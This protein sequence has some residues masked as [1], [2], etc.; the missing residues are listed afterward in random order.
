VVKPATEPAAGSIFAVDHTGRLHYWSGVAADVGQAPYGAIVSGATVLFKQPGVDRGPDIL[1][2]ER[3]AELRM[4]SPVLGEVSDRRRPGIARAR[5]AMNHAEPALGGD[6]PDS[7]AIVQF[8]DAEPW[9]LR[10]VRYTIRPGDEAGWFE[11]GEAAFPDPAYRHGF[12][13]IASRRQTAAGIRGPSCLLAGLEDSISTSHFRPLRS[14]PLETF[15]RIIYEMHIGTFTAEGT[16][17]AAASLLPP[18][19]ALG[20]T[21]LQLMPIDIG[22]GAPGWTYDQT[23]TGAVEPQAYGGP[24][25]LIRF[26]ERAHEVG[27]E[28]IVDKQYNHA[29]PEQD[30]REKFIRGMFPGTTQWG[31]GVSGGERSSFRQITKLI[32]EEM[33]FWV[34]YYGIDG[35]RLDATN[36]LP[37]ELH[38]AIGSFVREVE[39]LAGK[40]LYVVSEYAECEPPTGRRTPTGHQYTDQTGRCLM[41]LLGL[42]DAAHVVS[43]PADGSQLRTMLKAAKRGWWYP[44]VPPAAPALRGDERVTT[45]LWHHDW[46]GNRFG[47]ERLNHVVPFSLFKTIVAWQF[48]GQWTPL[49]FMGTER[50]AETPW[51]YFTGHRDTDTRNNTSAYYTTVNGEYVLSGGRFHEFAHEAKAAALSEPLAFSCD[52]TP[53]GIDW[54]AFRA[55]RDRTGRVYMDPSSPATF[56]ASKL[57]WSRATERQ[58]ASERLFAK[59]ASLRALPAAQNEDPANI[60]YKAWES[61]ERVFMV[62]RRA[63]RGTELAGFFN[64]GDKAVEIMI[65]PDTIEALNCGVPYVVSL[66]DGQ[67]ENEWEANGTYELWLNTNAKTFG[68]Q[69]EASPWC[70][71]V[72]DQQY[73]RF[74]LTENTALIFTRRAV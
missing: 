58:E 74:I 21:T 6:P 70:F 33:A 41:K 5:I 72:R 16:F 22:S 27:L 18:L 12:P 52:G 36:R 19:A 31:A 38:S 30:S 46:I 64:L 61:N 69:V 7:Y 9:L 68:G 25:G 42:S 37:W 44:D 32:G 4:A 14:H 73:E 63:S 50:C 59:L 55:Q 10:A 56:E 35:F 57:D 17:E 23:R 66:E 34:A 60:Q 28:V 47:G 54:N 24:F 2:I 20:I 49:L 15:E 48:L 51:F 3:P 71:L 39:R 11:F 65:G 45:L 62:R 67:P 40:P 8:A 53:A 43:L 29:G 13:D 26:V 1:I